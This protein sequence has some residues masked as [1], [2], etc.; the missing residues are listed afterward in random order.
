MTY[1]LANH[2]SYTILSPNVLFSYPSYLQWG[3]DSIRGDS[4]QKFLAK[5][6]TNICA[7]AFWRIYYLRCGRSNENCTMCVSVH[8]N[9][10]LDKILQSPRGCNDDL[11]HFYLGALWFEMVIRY[12]H[13]TTV[14][15]SHFSLRHVIAQWRCSNVHILNPITRFPEFCV[16][17]FYDLSERPKIWPYVYILKAFVLRAIWGKFR[18]KQE[19][20]SFL[21]RT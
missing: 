5:I 3:G 18:N 13:L 12:V 21:I 16:H 20:F 4:L 17:A 11:L 19:T 8:S 2:T 7:M 14:C 15:E 1:P 10:N 9:T 6:F